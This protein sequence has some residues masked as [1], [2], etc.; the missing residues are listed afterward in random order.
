MD[1]NNGEA[2]I[3]PF[4]GLWQELAPV[5]PRL[6]AAF[7]ILLAG[8]LLSVLAR[9]IARRS[10]VAAGVDQRF[11]GLW[12]FRIWR[13]SHQGQLPSVGL[14]S[15]VFYS[16]VFMTTVLAIRMLSA[17]MQL[18]AFSS[19][20]NVVPRV[21]SV[22]LTLL[23]GGLLGTFVSFVVQIVMAGSELPHATYWGKAAAWV[24]FS[25]GVMFS[26]EPLGLAGQILGQAVLIVLGAVALAVGLAFGLGCKELA[27]EF[28]LQI[29]S[30]D[31]EL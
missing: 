11:E 24:T 30:Q 8:L 27:R 6:T 3:E 4:A 12:V 10:M 23:L 29:L 1:L 31:K 22:V 20:L 16:G 9:G 28:L 21:L 7:S 14:A 19:L 26:L 5:L 17:E 15:L 2:W 18:G 13:R 25:A